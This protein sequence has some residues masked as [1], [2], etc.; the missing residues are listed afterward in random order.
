[1]R[2]LLCAA[3]VLVACGDESDNG[4]AK[5]RITQAAYDQACS[6]AEDFLVSR[7]SGDYFVQALCTAAAVE[8][9]TDAQAC[10]QQLDDCINMPPP[11][12]QAGIDAILAQGGCGLLSVN[13]ATCSSTL[14]EIKACLDAIDGEVS[15]L[16]YT[17]TCAAAGQSLDDWDL[18]SLPSECQFDSSC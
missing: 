11:E 14:G 8:G 3:L 17:L 16:K 2:L 1:M 7:Y 12:I 15:S 6:E 10:G 13:T 4:S 5:E 9:T 18:V